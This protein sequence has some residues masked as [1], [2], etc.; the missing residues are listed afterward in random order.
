MKTKPTTR[1]IPTTRRHRPRPRT[2]RRAYADFLALC[3]YPGM[4][5]TQPPNQPPATRG[6]DLNAF[7]TPEPGEL[8][9][10]Y[11]TAV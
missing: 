8:P 11:P 6:P 2:P 4:P 5:G 1:P 7:F 10:E 9:A 3:L